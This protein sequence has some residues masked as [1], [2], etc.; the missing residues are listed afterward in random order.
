MVLRWTL[1][2]IARKGYKERTITGFE[3]T[4]DINVVPDTLT[5][6]TYKFDSH[7]PIRNLIDN[8]TANIERLK[9]DIGDGLDT[10]PENRTRVFA[11]RAITDTTGSSGGWEF[12]SDNPSL[13]PV[14]NAQETPTAAASNSAYKGISIDVPKARWEAMDKILIT[15]THANQVV[16]A[17][18][19]PFYKADMVAGTRY[20]VGISGSGRVKAQMYFEE[21]KNQLGQADRNSNRLVIEVVAG[22]ST[23][24]Y[25]GEVVFI[26]NTGGSSSGTGDV[27]L[28]AYSTTAEV[29]T[30]D[31]LVLQNANNYT[32]DEIAK[33]PSTDLS[34]YSTTTQVDA[35]DQVILTAAKQYTD[36]NSGSTDL[37]GYDTSVEAN[38]KNEAIYGRAQAWANQQDEVYAAGLQ[39]LINSGDATTLQAAK[40][41]TDANAP[42]VDLSAYSTTAQVD[43]KDQAIL[44]AANTHAEGQDS[45]IA[46][47]LSQQITS[48][49]TATLNSAKDFTYSR[50]QIDTKDTADRAYTDTA[51]ARIPTTDLSPY[52]TTTQ[53]DAKD[54]AILAAAKAD[55]TTKDTAVLAAANAYTDENA[56]KFVSSITLDQNDDDKIKLGYSD[57]GSTPIELDWLPNPGNTAGTKTLLKVQRVGTEKRLLGS[58]TEDL[59]E[60]LNSLSDSAADN[61][62]LKGQH[63]RS[64]SVPL[65]R[66]DSSTQAKINAPAVDLSGYST[67]SQINAKDARYII[68]S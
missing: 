25:I 42:D 5:T 8:N 36:D 43:A 21:D 60:D 40:D 7:A 12:E 50:E 10:T 45:L 38:V 17:Q 6:K 33:I 52:S 54:Q 55:A 24:W 2:L 22:G 15:A 14:G 19:M 49:D 9:D 56:G 61:K 51:I 11:N 27:D 57:S 48:G 39:T 46:S 13:L 20:T 53:V 41:Y 67:T 64:G 18:F 68:T 44:T 63:I 34:D 58:T 59:Y 4:P 47:T 23:G 29:D 37:S 32:D 35:K 30:K 31:A 16:A 3:S 28:S 66:L 62:R 65:D 1:L 26:N